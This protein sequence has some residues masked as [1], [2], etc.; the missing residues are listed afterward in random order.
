MLA[1]DLLVWNGQDLRKQPLI[2]R[3]AILENTLPRM[4]RVVIARHIER[5]GEALYAHAAALELEGIV[6]K[7]ALSTYTAGRSD[8]WLKFKTPHGRH[9]DQERMRHLRP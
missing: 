3:K 4:R 5:Q 9:V 8:N 2:E 6:G 1:F 7:R